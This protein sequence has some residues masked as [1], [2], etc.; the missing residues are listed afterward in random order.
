MWHRTTW[1][2]PSS[3]GPAAPPSTRPAS[4]DHAAIGRNASR[5]AARALCATVIV[6]VAPSISATS[7]RQSNARAFRAG[8]FEPPAPLEDGVTFA[9]LNQPCG[10]PP[11]TKNLEP[12]GHQ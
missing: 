3:S 1:R 5:T 7:W 12:L 6:T 9:D 8:P 10:K 11:G 4:L 2:R